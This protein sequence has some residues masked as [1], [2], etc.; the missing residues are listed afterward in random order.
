[1]LAGLRERMPCLGLD[2][3]LPLM[4][5]AQ[6]ILKIRCTPRSVGRLGGGEAFS[7][8]EGGRGGGMHSVGGGSPGRGDAC[9]DRDSTFL[10][11]KRFLNDGRSLTPLETPNPSLY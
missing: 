9:Y 11:I 7:G 3:E 2:I 5:A 4:L 10:L 1:M 8:G 6:K